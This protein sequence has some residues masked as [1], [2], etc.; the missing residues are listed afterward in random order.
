MENR[1]K[2]RI[3]WCALRTAAAGLLTAALFC[4]QPALAA[5]TGTEV[6]EAAV[7]VDHQPIVTVEGNAVIDKSGNFT[8]F[9]ELALKVKTGDDGALTAFRSASVS[10]RYNASILTPVSWDYATIEDEDG[11]TVTV[12]QNYGDQ[13]KAMTG[14]YLYI[15]TKK[16]D[17]VITASAA[18]SGYRAGTGT[19]VN[20]YDTAL[21][22]LGAEAASEGAMFTQDTVVAIVRFQYDPQAY[23]MPEKNN[24]NRFLLGAETPEIA[25]GGGTAGYNTTVVWF[26]HDDEAAESPAGQSVWYEGVE[27]GVPNHLYY[28]LKAPALDAARTHESY[29][30]V[31]LPDTEGNAVFTADGPT[32]LTNLLT[33]HDNTSTQDPTSG[34]VVFKLI[35]ALSYVNNGI[36]LDNL[37]TILF[38]DWDDSLIGVLTAERGDARR[39]VNEYVEKNMIHPDLW[40]SEAADVDKKNLTDSLDRAYTYR[41]D[42]PFSGP[43]GAQSETRPDS[44]TFPGK[45]FPL[46]NKLEYSFYKY[47]TTSKETATTTGTTTETKTEWATHPLSTITDSA[48]LGLPKRTEDYPY[49][50]G[51]AIVEDIREIENVWTTFE[52]GELGGCSPESGTFQTTGESDYFKLADFSDLDVNFSD[53]DAENRVLYVK[54]CYVPGRE[55]KVGSPYKVLSGPTYI[56]YGAT[57]TSAGGVYA[58]GYQ[59]GRINTDGYGVSRTR[60]PSVQVNY[61]PDVDGEAQTPFA[62][63]VKVTNTDVIDVEFSPSSAISSLT[64]TLMDK[65]LYYPER[66]STVSYN[67]VT[68]AVRATNGNELNIPTNFN[69]DDFSRPDHLGSYGFVYIATLNQ[70]LEEGTKAVQEKD[71]TEFNNI[72]TAD[73]IVDMNWKRTTA[74]D[75]FT[76]LTM[77][78]GR[79][80]VL[81]A[82]RAAVDAG[83]VDENGIAKLE[84]HQIQYHILNATYTSSTDISGGLWN[85]IMPPDEAGS[86]FWC[87]LDDCAA[88][89]T[90]NI[91][92]FQDILSAARQANTGS[93]GLK[94]AALSALKKLD[95]DW[96]N[97]SGA[98]AANGLRLRGGDTGN[99]LADL[100]MINNAD[101]IARLLPFVAAADAQGDPLTNDE[102]AWYQLQ[103]ALLHNGDYQPIGSINKGDYWWK[104]KDEKDLPVDITDLA[105][106]LTAAKTYLDGNPVAWDDL[107][108]SFV[109][110]DLKLYNS[111]AGDA[112]SELTAFTAADAEAFKTKIEALVTA[113]GENYKTLTWYQVQEYLL[114]DALK[115]DGDLSRLFYWWKDDEYKLPVD[116]EKLLSAIVETADTGEMTAEQFGQW[117][118]LAVLTT[119]NEDPDG[120]LNGRTGLDFRADEAGTPYT[121]DNLATVVSRLRQLLQLADSQGYYDSAAHKLNLTW[122]QVQYYLMNR[123]LTDATTAEQ[124]RYEWRPGGTAHIPIVITTMEELLY[125]AYQANTTGVTTSLD[126]LTLSFAQGQYF[127]LPGEVPLSS[128]ADLAAVKAA[129]RA[130]VAAMGDDYENTTWDQIQYALLNG[131]AAPDAATA[132]AASDSSYWWMGGGKKVTDLETL[133]AALAAAGSASRPRTAGLN[134]VTQ[135]VVT[136]ALYLKADL[137]G[138]TDLTLED[139]Q[140]RIQQLAAAAGSA[141]GSLT[142]DQI[143]Y[144]MIHDATAVPGGSTAASESSANYW[145]K[146]GGSKVTDLASLLD[147]AHRAADGENAMMS[148]VTL[149]MVQ[150]APFWLKSSNEGDDYTLLAR[151]KNNM[152]AAVTA[153]GEAGID[154]KTLT[155]GQ[156]QYYLINGSIPSV[157]DAQGLID[158]KTY[159]WYEGGS[160]PVEE[161]ISLEEMLQM[162]LTYGLDPSIVSQDELFSKLTVEFFAQAGLKANATGADITEGNIASVR[163]KIASLYTKFKTKYYKNGVLSISWNQLQYFIIKGSATTPATANKQNYA[164]A[165]AD[166]QTILKISPLS[167]Y[168]VMEEELALLEELPE[169]AVPSETLPEGGALPEQPETP[170]VPPVEEPGENLPAQPEE[171]VLPPEEAPKEEPPAGSEEPDTPPAVDPEG[172]DPA[173]PEKPNLPPPEEPTEED[174][175]P[176]QPEEEPPTQ[177]E[178]PDL[179]P[180]GETEEEQPPA[181]ADREAETGEEEESMAP[182]SDPPT[183]ETDPGPNEFLNIPDTGQANALLPVTDEK[184]LSLS[185]LETRRNYL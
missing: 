146:D 111:A 149:D 83:Y 171:P 31:Q 150:G 176:D 179:P 2:S 109:T 68:G 77:S 159:W 178:E 100:P 136:N 24:F 152:I 169:Q 5:V 81:D 9:F 39:E 40:V 123:R 101:F 121:A 4:A 103:H 184:W 6:P 108:M 11:N 56:R 65:K 51:W 98:S 78:R 30:S 66:M 60:D 75:G 8:G 112:R 139:F 88:N 128:D 57:A 127:Y 135:P 93:G 116:V 87:H 142:W 138:T 22:T 79:A 94:D 102:D 42:Y 62:S 118:T 23:P 73:T 115:D 45:D 15:D 104:V 154:Y 107:D 175:L 55:I 72:L 18:V 129:A 91:N 174:P 54:A 76:T 48:A 147:A 92:S 170:V 67:F 158:D 167:T 96:V 145:W 181:P 36:D 20:G 160:K 162:A 155:W 28:Y 180:E 105:S 10:L 1:R 125:A 114:T 90:I 47:A 71:A 156:I 126:S 177:P 89:I 140:T 41:G 86:Y 97:A 99:T 132:Q 168:T 16:D 38:Y 7:A 58:I 182:G 122:D 74:G 35:N 46:T 32:Y 153:A 144:A 157:D 27:G 49:V 13:I 137:A 85:R 26:S 183:V 14:G 69:Y 151:F 164:W 43:S 21:I 17:A 113:A 130:A 161:A 52:V 110:S 119:D 80:L 143:Q 61:A 131:T 124:K 33:I 70:I 29:P 44:A 172:G 37:V 25:A 148:T 59:Y 166:A 133:Q 82:I 12:G 84:W 134:T 34:E 117:F 120:S 173:E 64:Y 63:E 53:P 3:K 106:L 95:M 165:P 141:A 50:H 185:Q 19:G 163:S